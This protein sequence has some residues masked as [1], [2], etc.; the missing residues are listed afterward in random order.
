MSLRTDF[1]SKISCEHR[2]DLSTYLNQVMNI[3]LKNSRRK[4]I[5]D[6]KIYY[7][8]VADNINHKKRDW[9]GEL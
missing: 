2:V 1:Q 7:L 3:L 4:L 5:E 8:S 6:G 9:N